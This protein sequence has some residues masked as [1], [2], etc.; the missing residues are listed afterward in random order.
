MSVGETLRPVSRTDHN[1]P[2]PDCY[3]WSEKIV[4]AGG[5]CLRWERLGPDGPR[6][7]LKQFPIEKDI[8]VTVRSKKKKTKK[9]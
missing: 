8:H 1:S 3:D 5:W 2:G 6:T 7:L 9:T 4:Y